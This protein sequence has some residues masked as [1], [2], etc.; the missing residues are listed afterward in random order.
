MITTEPLLATSLF[1]T[2][3]GAKNEGELEC[4]WCSAPCK[5]LWLHDDPP[6]VPFTRTRSSARRPNSPHICVGCW[7][8]RRL[9][10]TVRYLHNPKILKD[11]QCL[12]NHSWWITPEGT[13]VID[14][15]DFAALYERLLHPPL[16]FALS[17]KDGDNKS[18]I[19]LQQANDVPKIEGGTPLYFYLNNT[20]YTY[21]VCDLE[22]CLNGGSVQGKEPGVDAL[23]HFL[24]ASDL[25]GN[26][27]EVK[28]PVG[29]PKKENEN[30]N[31]S[32]VI[33]TSGK[34]L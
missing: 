34:A 21:S 7:L 24:G 22:D 17:L 31:K 14:S 18:L 20:R 23:I 9:R 30:V 6:P 1:A 3:Q 25:Q 4:H 28:N 10:V 16:Q 8:Y 5:R 19:Q 13:W 27:K 2:S 15:L 29:R 32:K 26:H 33:V 11:G 12:L